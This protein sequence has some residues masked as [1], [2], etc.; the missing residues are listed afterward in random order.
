MHYTELPVYK[1]RE[2]IL[3]AL[4]ENQVIILESPT[5]SGKT[6]TTPIILHEA[7]YDAQGRIC[8]TQPRRI[9]A[10]NVCD[11][12]K[13]Q[14]HDEGTY[15]GC[16]MR[17]YD[18]T[19]ENTHI[20]I[21]TD[22]ELLQD[23]KS[24]PFMSRYSV[25]LV[26]EVHER[27]LNVDFLLGLIKE[28]LPHR[29]DLKVILSSATI[30]TQVFSEFFNNAP[31]IY[32][33]SKPYEVEVQYSPAE[34][35]TDKFFKQ[36]K[37]LVSR[38]HRE[39]AGDILIFLPGEA[40]IKKCLNTLSNCEVASQLDIYP[41]FG[42]LSREEQNQVFNPTTPGHTKVVIATNL[43]ETSITIDGITRVIDSGVCKM[44]IYSQTNFTSTL[45][46]V[47]TSK[48]SCNQRKGRAGRTQPGVCYRLFSEENYEGRAEFT[49]EEILHEDLAEIVLRMSELGIYDVESFPF[50]TAP[51]REEFKSAE[52][53]LIDIGAINKDHTLTN[54]GEYMIKFPIIPRLGRIIVEA[55]LN[56]PDVM[57]EVLI[58]VAFLSTKAPFVYPPDEEDIARDAHH[59]LLDNKNGD[60][61]AWLK[62][63][64]TY[65]D[66]DEDG[67]K[68]YCEANFL[69]QQTMDEIVNIK[70]QLEEMISEMGIPISSSKNTHLYLNCIASGLKQYICK[71]VRKGNYK[72]A[73][74]KDISIHPGAARPEYEPEYLLAGEI[75]KTT[76]MYVRSWASLSTEQ[77][78]EI[79]ENLYVTLNQKDIN[80]SDLKKKEKK[81]A[82]S[83]L[84]R[85]GYMSKQPVDFKKIKRLLTLIPDQEPLRQR[86]TKKINPK[87]DSF[88]KIKT[89]LDYL[90]KP[91][92]SD[93]EKGFSYIALKRVHGGYVLYSES[94]IGEAV[95]SSI[96]A[97]DSLVDELPKKEQKS[98]NIL[99]KKIKEFSAV[100]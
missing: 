55:V 42:R 49:E 78:K 77:V 20:S 80:K 9:A 16:K 65:Y 46:T 28:V 62:I 26:D 43:A 91:Y 60:F 89:Y 100:L 17:F 58:T 64:K 15:V 71:K 70:G 7:G 33:D 13:K 4:S 97:M 52:R 2:E 36:I 83:Y 82:A 40:D 30:N 73:G 34:Y 31:I 94:N 63:Y 50:I 25:L 22:G 18:T 21:L 32:I 84:V 96:K 68:A 1:H 54:I 87:S 6:V 19:D 51:E 85:G 95:I 75:V 41:L 48:A 10:L 69:D 98:R 24:D 39:K 11:F 61:S 66:L 27:S 37:N 29:P 79:D 67:K 90:M 88:G 3:K 5:G 47:E 53:T 74:C 35:G 56:Y 23:M 38:F 81:T 93:E 86:P 92:M 76:K 57:N 8:I 59:E 45:A 14:L 99:I 44:N 12:I 72:S